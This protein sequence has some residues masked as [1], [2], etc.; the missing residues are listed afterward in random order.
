[1]WTKH[2]FGPGNIE[3]LIKPLQHTYVIIAFCRPLP[4]TRNAFCIAMKQINLIATITCSFHLPRGSHRQSIHIIIDP[5][6]IILRGAI[7]HPG[8]HRAR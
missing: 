4:I 7:R 8:G 1:M 6:E 2:Y 5:E 3:A